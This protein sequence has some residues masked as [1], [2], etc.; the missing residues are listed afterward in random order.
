VWER[1]GEVSDEGLGAGVGINVGARL[2]AYAK[3]V[4]W[5]GTRV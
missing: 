4:A 5:P 1:V 2:Y 3:L